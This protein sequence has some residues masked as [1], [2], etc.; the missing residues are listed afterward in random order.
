MTKTNPISID[1]LRAEEN[2]FSAF[3][4]AVEALS[5][6]NKSETL[7]AGIRAYA[8]SPH[9]SVGKLS[10]TEGAGEYNIYT[11]ATV[12]TP[13]KLGFLH[14][15]ADHFSTPE[16]TIRILAHEIEH[17]RVEEQGAVIANARANA[18]NRGDKSAYEA[19]CNLTEGYAKYNE[20]KV[21]DEIIATIRA[22]AAAEGPS[23]NLR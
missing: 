12:S 16:G 3:N 10:A 5:L 20:V 21:R 6:I 17:F 23:A 8:V 4:I 22:E 11:E 19:A 13:E 15:A 18:L 1:W 9:V 7:K 2:G 14:I